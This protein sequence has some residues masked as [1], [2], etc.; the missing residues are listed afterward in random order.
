MLGV[1]LGIGSHI[2]KV[3]YNVESM[4]QD[5]SALLTLGQGS[6][7]VGAVL[8]TEGCLQ[9]PWTLLIRCQ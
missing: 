7:L 3:C 6:F 2:T 8:C 9:H 1:L 5:N 4:V